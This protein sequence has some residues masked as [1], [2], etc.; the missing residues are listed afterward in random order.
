[1]E[2]WNKSNRLRWACCGGWSFSYC[3]NSISG[4]YQV[5]QGFGSPCPF[6]SRIHVERIS[7]SP[8]VLHREDLNILKS[9]LDTLKSRKKEYTTNT[10]LAVH[11]SEK[12]C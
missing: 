2:R 12:D 3:L 4:V 7:L 10:M 1:M 5:G 8:I 9:W 6:S 11:K